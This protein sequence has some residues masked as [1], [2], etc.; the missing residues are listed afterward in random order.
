MV[1]GS[2]E[3]NYSDHWAKWSLLGD[4][5]RTKLLLMTFYDFLIRH[6]KKKRKVMF[7]EIWKKTKNAY[8]RTLVS[9]KRC[10]LYFVLCGVLWWPR[11]CL[12]VC[13]SV[14]EHISGTLSPIFAKFFARYLLPWLGP[15]PAALW[16]VMCFRLLWM[17][18]YLPINGPYSAAPEQPAS[19]MVQSIG[20]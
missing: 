4:V 16:Y 2:Q 20:R 18:S 7:F 12:S 19:L 17:T 3:L 1:L 15:P 6:F 14:R 11:F 13:L 5:L 10:I 9:C 8:S